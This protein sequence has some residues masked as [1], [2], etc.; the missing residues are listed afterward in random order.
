MRFTQTFSLLAAALA[1]PSF[2]S[3]AKRQGF[4]IIE[5]PGSITAPAD[6][7]SVTVGQPFTLGIAV[8]E[9]GHCHPGYTAVSIYLLAT[10]STT[11]SLNSTQG[12]SDYLYYF[13]EYLVNNFPG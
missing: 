1:V 2:A 8:P 9:F 5:S 4:T 3:P 13:G 10:Q 6:G 12:F 7:T 11:S